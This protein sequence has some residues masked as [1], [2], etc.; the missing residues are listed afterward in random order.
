M[1]S[2]TPLTRPYWDENWNEELFSCYHELV[3]Y[4]PRSQQE[5]GEFM[6]EL[7]RH[8]RRRNRNSNETVQNSPRLFLCL[9]Y[10]DYLRQTTSFPLQIYKD[11]THYMNTYHFMIGKDIEI[12]DIIR[13]YD[14]GKFEDWLEDQW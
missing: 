2:T 13:E 7:Y 4:C 12:F 10:K 3:N 8:E 9:V 5:V 11:I 1:I 14:H 6:E